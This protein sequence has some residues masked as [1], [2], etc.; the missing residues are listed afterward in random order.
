GADAVGAAGGAEAR[1]SALMPAAPGAATGSSTWYCA[2]GT[3]DGASGGAGMA[4]HTV[5]IV[6]PTA[7]DLDA[8]LTV[9]AGAVVPASVPAAGPT[10]EQ[11]DLPAGERVDVRL[12]DL[13]DAPLAAAVVEVDGGDVAVEH[14]VSGEHGT[15]VTPCST[16]A[17]ATWHFA[18][19]ATTR[20]ARDIVVLFNPFPSSA[21]VDAVFTTED[22]RREP[23]RF[24]GLPVPAGSVVGVDLGDDVTRSE[25]V[26]ATFAARSG[27]VVAEHLQVYDGSLGVRGLA[28]T[29]GA[30]SGGLAWVFPDGEAAAPAPHTP[31]PGEADASDGGDGAAGARGEGSPDDEAT[32]TERIVVYNPGDQRAEVEVRAIPTAE[33]AGP[34]PQPF[35]LSIGPGGYE[36]VD[37]G[38]HDRIEAGVTHATVVR[39]TNGRPVVAERVTVDAGEISATL[40][41]RLAAPRWAFPSVAGPD[42]RATAT[43]VVFNPD[44]RAAVEARLRLLAGPTPSGAVGRAPPVRVPPGARVAVEV[45]ADRAAAAVAAVVEADGAVVVERV[46]RTAEGSRA[47]LGAGVPVAAEAETLDGLAAGGRPA[48]AAG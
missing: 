13:V 8:T 24:Q 35:G 44:P 26:S 29:P 22:G 23:V 32:T 43:F 10:T 31:A 14:R 39:S 20:D 5:A 19:G 30:G 12:G 11:V 28:L 47:S 34:A 18:W 40:G 2:A 1:P 16:S 21:T 15:D 3:A 36:M 4:D 38:G 6:N 9:F 48:L 42:D 37:Y 17:A 41:A 25:Q 45:D 33:R 27:R 46:I 7:D